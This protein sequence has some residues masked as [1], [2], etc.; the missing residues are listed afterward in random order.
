MM[1]S[2]V[3]VNRS[4]TSSCSKNFL[5]AG[6]DNVTFEADVSGNNSAFTFGITLSPEFNRLLS[7]GHRGTSKFVNS[8]FRGRD[9][10]PVWNR[11]ERPQ[12]PRESRGGER[13]DYSPRQDRPPSKSP[14]ERRE[15][16]PPGRSREA[17]PD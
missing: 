13:R 3:V 16:T 2:L 6:V 1:P 15:V 14:Q 8:K 10:T 7:A 5:V 11:A 9:A 17:E 12:N 4:Y